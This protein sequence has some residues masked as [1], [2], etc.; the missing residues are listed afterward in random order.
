MI[1]KAAALAASATAHHTATGRLNRAS[2]GGGAAAAAPAGDLPARDGAPWR[3]SAE[4]ACVVAVAFVWFAIG[5]LTSA[6]AAA[7]ATCDGVSVIIAERDAAISGAP[8]RAWAARGARVVLVAALLVPVAL[9]QP[10]PSPSPP[11]TS[12]TIAATEGT[13]CGAAGGEADF[14]NGWVEFPGPPASGGGLRSGY[15]AYPFSC[16]V[17]ST[18]AWEI[19]AVSTD[20]GSDS[21]LMQVDST[22]SEGWVEWHFHARSTLS[23][24]S[25][26]WSPESTAV[27][28]GAGQHTL[29]VA[30]KEVRTDARAELPA[31]DPALRLTTPHLNDIAICS[32]CSQD[33]VYFDQLRFSQGVAECGFDDMSAIEQSSTDDS[34]SSMDQSALPNWVPRRWHVVLKTNGDETFEC[35]ALLAC[36]LASRRYP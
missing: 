35:V 4:E 20:G 3:A 8:A 18:V 16:T 28:V 9:A 15:I 23:E 14:S 6:W 30:E 7:V 31:P 10:S 24:M 2:G 27:A 29:F 34:P 21:A 13:D 17:P 12:P 19:S 26:A 22:D 1:A 33:G 11:S 25:F 36:V 32:R 5:A